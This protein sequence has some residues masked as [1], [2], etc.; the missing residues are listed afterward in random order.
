LDDTNLALGDEGDKP[1]IDALYASIVATPFSSRVTNVR[2]QVPLAKAE[3]R[4]SRTLGPLL[5]CRTTALYQ[6][7]TR[8]RT[9]DVNTPAGGGGDLAPAMVPEDMAG[10]V[11]GFFL[12]G[13]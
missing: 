10:L 4:P 7:A 1:T 2:L 11:N 8:R 9:P 5:E 6:N 3:Q 13:K 12:S